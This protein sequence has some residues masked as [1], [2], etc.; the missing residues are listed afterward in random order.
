MDPGLF[1]TY[2]SSL[3]PYQ[4][5]SLSLTMDSRQNAVPNYYH[6]QDGES[7]EVEQQANVF[8]NTTSLPFDQSVYHLD[9]L[10]SCNSPTQFSDG[11]HDETGDDFS[12]IT[13][14][15]INIWELP[16][17]YDLGQSYELGLP[18]QSQSSYYVANGQ[19]HWEGKEEWELSSPQA[20][21]SRIPPLVKDASPDPVSIHPNHFVPTSWTHQRR[22]A[23]LYHGFYLRTNP[24]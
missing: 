15:T 10:K 6:S 18:D 24:T 19:S 13:I 7:A 21:T 5:L 23:Q 3:S 12:V 17:S 14:D 16:S 2:K 22:R 1:I 20:S 11:L 4:N 8:T 9:I